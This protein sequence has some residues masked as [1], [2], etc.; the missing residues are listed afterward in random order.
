MYVYILTKW[1]S[2]AI[3]SETIKIMLKSSFQNAKICSM[4]SNVN[5]LEIQCKRAPNTSSGKF[6]RGPRAVKISRYMHT[7]PNPISQLTSEHKRRW[8]RKMKNTR[9][10]MIGD[11]WKHTVEKSQK[12][13]H[14]APY[15][16][17]T[18][19][20][21]KSED[22][23]KMMIGEDDS[24]EAVKIVASTFA[25]Y[26]KNRWPAAFLLA[27]SK[28]RINGEKWKSWCSWHR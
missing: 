11:I 28:I 25:S 2:M 14:I 15:I 1:E 17:A 6:Q 16:S 10:M 27:I 7:T 23:W 19:M 3:S 5:A 13:T 24:R 4:R 12:H 21:V 18:K 22:R 8:R 9:L 26:L 20:M